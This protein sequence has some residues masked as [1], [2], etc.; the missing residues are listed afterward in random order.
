VTALPPFT[1]AALL[2]ALISAPAAILSGFGTRAGW[3]DFKTGFQ[4]LTWAAYGA[5][6]SAVVGAIGIIIALWHKQPRNAMISAGVLVLGVMVIGIPW[7]MKRTAQN[8]PAIHDISTDTDHPPEF[9]ALLPL[10]KG[11]PNGTAYGGPDIAGQQHKA[12]PDIQPL[13]L[14]VPREKAFK[15]AL[16]TMEAMGWD[17]IDVSPEEGRIEAT[18][19]TFWFGFK[20]DIVVRVRDQGS[21]S[22]V[23][24]RSV[25]RVG[26]SDVGTNAKRIRKYEQKLR[27][28]Q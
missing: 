19:T 4:I 7:Q 20:D 6:G 13:T 14:H 27:D 26:R 8:V 23:D 5:L 16:K 1:R 28:A 15:Q 17:V 12:Y 2:L 21:G 22:L 11:A 3:W 18:D 10:R 24:V 25:S 9:V